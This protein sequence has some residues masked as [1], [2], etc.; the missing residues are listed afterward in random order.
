[1]ILIGGFFLNNNA[2]KNCISRC[3]SVSY[4]RQSLKTR[5]NTARY[6]SQACR[7]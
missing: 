2:H 7:Q 1:M 3:F 5:Q 4:C 6:A